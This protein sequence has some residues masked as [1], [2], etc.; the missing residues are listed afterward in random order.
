MGYPVDHS[1][2]VGYFVLVRYRSVRAQR[3]APCVPYNP[4]ITVEGR[5]FG[6]LN[7][8]LLSAYMVKINAVGSRGAFL[9]RTTIAERWAPS[10]VRNE[11]VGVYYQAR[12]Y[13]QARDLRFAAVRAKAKPTPAIS[14]C[15]RTKIFIL[16]RVR[17]D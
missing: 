14:R 1:V 9:R 13:P 17:S 5:P 3:F 2:Y 6:F 15:K 11:Y 12:L 7:M 10:F 4:G 8:L 16:L